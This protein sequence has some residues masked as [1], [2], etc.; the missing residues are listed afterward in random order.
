ML[1]AIRQLNH[2]IT[3]SH[4]RILARWL[5]SLSCWKVSALLPTS[6]QLSESD[7]CSPLC[8]PSYVTFSR[9]I[10]NKDY[11]T[12]AASILA[13]EAQHDAWVS[14][15]VEQK[16]GWDTAYETPLGLSGVYSL[17]CS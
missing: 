15:A 10:E 3:P 16:A 2:A 5:L 13:V 14:S 6:V 4:T 17:A 9:F 1:W 11:L 7:A 12:A 8:M